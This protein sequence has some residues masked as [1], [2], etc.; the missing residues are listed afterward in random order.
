MKM[1]SLVDGNARPAPLLEH[2]TFDAQDHL[3]LI[4]GGPDVLLP[5]CSVVFHADGT[6]RPL[7]DAAKKDLLDVQSALASQGRRVVLVARRLVPAVDYATGTLDDAD[8]A[9]RALDLATDLAVCGLLAIVD[10][11]KP[12]TAH[13]VSR[14]RGAGIRFCMCAARVTG[15]KHPV[16]VI[17]RTGSRAIFRR[18]RRPSRERWASSPPTGST[19]SKTSTASSIWHPSRPTPRCRR[20]TSAARPMTDR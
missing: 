7:D 17:R 4:K 5:R 15:L 3:L 8:L 14:A 20:S 13:T 16:D 10:P 12:D 1:F 9:R 2:D 18:R 19:P 11:P 6:T